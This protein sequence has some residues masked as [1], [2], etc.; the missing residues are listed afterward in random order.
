MN[1]GLVHLIF[2]VLLLA[3]AGPL[4]RGQENQVQN[5]EFDNG[6]V[7]W[8]LY[9]AAGFTVS[10]V[11]GARLSGPNAA[12]LDVTDPSV[13]SIGIAQGNLKFERGKKYPIGLMAKADK[14]REMV[15]LIQ[16][17]KPEG[18]TWTDIVLQHVSL[19]TEPQTFVF[20]YTH[21]DDSMADH[22][23][24]AADMYLMLK[25]QWWPM[26]GDTVASKVWV[27]RVHVGQQPPLADSRIR[28]ASAPA[29]AQDAGDVSCD[30]G[31]KWTPGEFAG[32]HD[33]YFG[34]TFADVNAASR[35][36]P[37]GVQVSQ[38]QTDAQYDPDGLLAYGQ[39]YYWRIDE[40]NKTPDNTIFKGNVWSFTV[41]PYSYAL[42]G[43]K[44]TA[45]SSQP[46][47]GPEKTVDGSGLTGDLHGTEA[48]TMWMS[49]GTKPNWIQYEFNAVSK[50]DKL[51]VWNSNQIIEAFIGFGAK[52]VTVEYSVDGVTWAALAGVPPFGQ[53]TGLPNYAANNTVNFGGVMAKFVK[54]TINKNWSGVATQT[55]LA[56]TRFFYIPVR[57]R[58]PQ[59][60]AGATG[61]SISGDL[62]WRPG[63]EA[64]SHQVSFGT[65]SNAVAAGTVTAQTVTGHSLTPGP[66][67]LGTQYYWKVDEIGG[68]GPYAGDL[69]S[70]TTREYAVVD[71]FEAYNDTDN[72]IYDNWIDGFDNPKANGAI[73]GKAQAPFAEQTIIHGG[74]QS[75][76]LSYDNTGTTLSE[77]QLTLDQNWT[78]SG[79]KSLSLYFRGA[80]GNKG[81][82]YVKINNVKVAYDGA[83]GD[84][85]AA[86]WLPW[87]ID[88]SKVATTLSKVKSL[89]IGVEGAGA[90]GMLY[91]DDIRLYPK[92]PEFVVP[93]PPSAAGLVARYTFD[94][95]L[96][97]SVGTHHGTAF[98][99]AKVAADPVHGQVL[100]VDGN[101]DGVNVPYSA[102]LNPPAFTVSLWAN[103]SS[104]GSDYRSPI[105]SRGDAPQ[106]GY[107]LY[108]E[109]GN[110][111]QLWIGTGTGWDTTAGPA[112]QLD[113]WAHVTA[114]FAGDQKM[115]YLNG[116][117]VAQ[118]T[119]P[120]SPNTQWPLRIGGGATETTVGNYFFRGL[121][122]DV[123]LYNRALSA[124]E[125]A[126][127]AGRT[128]PLHK[129]F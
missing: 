112:A 106:K 53:G 17:Y 72:R 9:G 120:L 44:A 64:T 86:S 39:T 110:T 1:R 73:V 55:G 119:A 111:W 63:R 71:D 105:T 77:A 79:I 102:D 88:L 98:G 121:I 43:V 107:I 41:E 59:P 48:S 49:T 37:R 95:N 126:G 128:Q 104:A 61:V 13:A 10:V 80:A 66:L 51:L 47:M 23:A 22:P 12:L 2:V 5:P 45:S 34:K 82:L 20:E 96:K 31:L 87:N 58:A 89:T 68:A 21:N 35:N 76:P 24:W 18:P 14:P 127:L 114:T 33:V 116:R 83:A 15:I 118:G 94:G 16:L 115:L 57:A 113:E 25:G 32:T 74:R 81:Q 42:A 38:G 29:P 6:L 11:S 103:P 27:D 28:A 108:V 7:S 3:G 54:L 90:A 52:D 101:G 92:A 40:V 84:S 85:A 67:N 78:V 100:A 8:G 56:E 30:T 109:P 124:E 122:D 117:L 69:W 46:N 129:A 123:C 62:N 50:L 93:V 65:D 26:T 70:F 75:M 91:I 125:V 99:D 36:D 4:A 97:D 19:T 60:A